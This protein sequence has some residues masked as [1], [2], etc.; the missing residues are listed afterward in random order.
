MYD[1]MHSTSNFKP[2][3]WQTN[4]HLQT[5]AAKLFRRKQKLITTA[6]TTH[7]EVSSHVGFIHGNNP[8]NPQYWLEQRVPDFLS[9]HILINTQK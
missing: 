6:R 7:F 8:F 5:L 1:I 3:W 9:D 4:A 2:A